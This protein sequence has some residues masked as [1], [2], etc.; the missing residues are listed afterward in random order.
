MTDKIGET[1]LPGIVVAFSDKSTAALT[2]TQFAGPFF[3]SAVIVK[4]FAQDP[5]GNFLP[6][7]AEAKAY[8]AS[9]IAQ[10]FPGRTPIEVKLTINRIT[11]PLDHPG[12]D[13]IAGQIAVQHIVFP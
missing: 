2:P 11:F 13:T 1:N 9:R 4:Y 12:D 6:V 3:P 10:L 5:A 8:A 7:T